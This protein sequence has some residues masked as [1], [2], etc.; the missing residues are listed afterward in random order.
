MAIL[1]EPPQNELSALQNLSDSAGFLKKLGDGNYSIDNNNYLPLSGGTL[2]NNLS[3]NGTL[4]G[5]GSGL[6]SLNASNISTGTLNAARLPASYLPLSGG[7]VTGATT[8]SNKIAVGQNFSISSISNYSNISLG[9]NLTSEYGQSSIEIPTNILYG[10]NSQHHTGVRLACGEMGGW[11][12]ARLKIYVSNDWTTYNPIACFSV[13]DAGGVFTGSSKATS[14]FVGNNQ[15]VS[16]RK[17]GWSAP[18]GT[19]TRTTFFTGTVTL[20]QLAERVKGLIDD[21]T[22]HGLIGA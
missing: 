8:F 21:L 17:T 15:V 12:T 5:N 13:G 7:T 22:A 19:A 20:S 16:S 10:G 6:T 1:I 18:T 14:F 2:T 11:G 3:V 9:N 4:S